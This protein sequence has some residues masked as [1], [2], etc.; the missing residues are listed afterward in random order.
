M[1][2]WSVYTTDNLRSFCRC[3]CPWVLSTFF[4]QTRP[5]NQNQDF[6]SS[7]RS[8]AT[9]HHGLCF[10]CTLLCPRGHHTFQSEEE[11]NR[12]YGCCLET[13]EAVVACGG[14]R[15]RLIV[16]GVSLR[17]LISEKYIRKEMLISPQKRVC[18]TETDMS[19]SFLCPFFVFFFF[20]VSVFV[21]VIVQRWEAEGE[22]IDQEHAACFL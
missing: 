6:K 13:I 9:E 18:S 15:Q 7:A 8:A 10:R 1:I 16:R 21:Y 14:R 3:S 20:P 11:K 2:W 22:K 17:K 19:D 12:F 5:T 4:V